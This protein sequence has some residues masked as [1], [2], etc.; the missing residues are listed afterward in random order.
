M[1]IDASAGPAFPIQPIRTYRTSAGP[2][3]KPQSESREIPEPLPP[4]RRDC[5]LSEASA[6][7]LASEAWQTRFPRKNEAPAPRSDRPV[8]D[9]SSAR[10]RAGEDFAA[11]AYSAAAAA[12]DSWPAVARLAR[13]PRQL[14]K[15][16]G[17]REDF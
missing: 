5:S 10:P 2:A 1:R 9:R 3:A 15:S 16:R 14:R 12:V 6:P 8:S 11:P 7:R 4:E 13:P 17:W